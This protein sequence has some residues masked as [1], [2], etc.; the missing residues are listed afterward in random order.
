MHE[1]AI[2]QGVVDLV[3][4]RTAG[5]RVRAVHVRV[6]RLSGVV[7]DAMSFCFEIAS[8]GTPVEGAR[9]EIEET[10]GRIQCRRCGLVSAVD[11]LFWLCPCGS[12]DVAVVSGQELMVVSVEVEKATTCA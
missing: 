6:G 5:R 7:A 12:A 4:G 3:A 10:E 9:L 2:T 1:L 8:A 11:D